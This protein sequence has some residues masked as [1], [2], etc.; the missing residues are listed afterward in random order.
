M[1][2]THQFY[3]FI[4]LSVL[5]FSSYKNVNSTL[6]GRKAEQPSTDVEDCNGYY[7]LSEGISFELTYY[8]KKDKP[9]AIYKQRIVDSKDIANGVE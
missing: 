1:K 7:P 6:E 2:N 9:S 3:V 4:I 5:V 8:D